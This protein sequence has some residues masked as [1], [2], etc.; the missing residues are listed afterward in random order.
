MLKFKFT[1]SYKF[2]EEELSVEFGACQQQSNDV[3][4][5]FYSVANVQLTLV[6]TNIVFS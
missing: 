6:F 4:C 3:D 1:T 5:R 2:F